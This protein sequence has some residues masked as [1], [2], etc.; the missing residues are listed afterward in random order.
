MVQQVTAHHQLLSLLLIRLIL[1]QRF[2]RWG[3]ALECKPA[4]APSPT[5]PSGDAGSVDDRLA[6]G[7]QLAAQ[8][9]DLPDELAVFLREY[10]CCSGASGSQ[11]EHG[12]RGI[13]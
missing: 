9:V 3:S 12:K 6:R 4:A 7:V 11:D 2:L 10:G 13:G 8:L 1:A 5:M